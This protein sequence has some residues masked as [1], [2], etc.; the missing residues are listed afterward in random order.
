MI[1]APDSRPRNPLSRFKGFGLVTAG[2]TAAIAGAYALDR[3][4]DAA[5]VAQMPPSMAQVMV[6]DTVNIITGAE[7]A[8][9]YGMMGTFE[10]E[11]ENQVGRD[12]RFL[13]NHFGKNM[14]DREYV[15][16]GV[17]AQL[18]ADLSEDDLVVLGLEVVSRHEDL[19]KI[20][21]DAAES[22]PKDRIGD[23][24]PKSVAALY[25][26]NEISENEISSHFKKHGH[27]YRPA[28]MEST[29]WQDLDVD[30]DV[31]MRLVELFNDARV[32]VLS[33][34]PITISLVGASVAPDIPKPDESFE[35]RVSDW[36]SGLA[37]MVRERIAPHLQTG[38][39]PFLEVGNA[40]NKAPNRIFGD[41][42]GRN[43]ARANIADPFEN[44]ARMGL[45]QDL[46]DV[47]LGKNPDDP[48]TTVE[49]ERKVEVQDDSP[50]PL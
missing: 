44:G 35:T 3:A 33:P 19:L 7:S 12:F 49:I 15:K 47:V 17:T 40:L 21:D 1:K 11:S 6:M 18:D 43:L 9:M 48:F 46:V 16:A 41:G 8:F 13:M 22:L 32:E 50:A 23:M 31:T 39:S 5:I 28:R 34:E 2:V 26:I 10:Q 27:Y 45:V 29:L 25:I 38:S 42:E 30:R 14:T 4:A 37:D 20:L 24:D 36:E